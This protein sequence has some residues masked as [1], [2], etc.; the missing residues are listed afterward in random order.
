MAASPPGYGRGMSAPEAQP[1][2]DG[3]RRRGGTRLGYVVAVLVNLALWYLVNVR[4]GWQ[5][6][7][8]LTEDFTQ[9]LDV[10]NLSLLAGA[11]ANAAYLGYDAAWFRSLTQIGLLGISL[12]VLYRMLV[13]FPFDLQGEGTD[14]A[15]AARVLLV[16]GL[17]G[18]G[19]GLLAEAGRLVRALAGGGRG[20]GT[21]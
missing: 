15:W 21:A 13:V 20:G 1:A 8:F 11:V 7:P 17:V 9:V 14:W 5:E 12:V 16:L 6:I 3:A 2:A 4:P 10:L 19:I 18:T